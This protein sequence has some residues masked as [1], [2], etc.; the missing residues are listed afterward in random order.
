MSI[1]SSKAYSYIVKKGATGFILFALVCLNLLVPHQH[2]RAEV[3][4]T[5]DAQKVFDAGSFYDVIWS[6]PTIT[7]TF[8]KYELANIGPV[9]GETSARVSR[10]PSSTERT[11]IEKAFE[12][13]DRALDSRT[14]TFT[15]SPNADIKVGFVERQDHPWFFRFYTRSQAP[16]RGNLFNGVIGFSSLDRAIINEGYFSALAHRRVANVLGMGLIL[17][18]NSNATVMKGDL[19]DIYDAHSGSSLKNE[20]ARYVPTDYEIGLIR[21]LYGESTC[22][23]DFGKKFDEER[24]KEA[25]KQEELEKARKAFEDA[26][27]RADA[28]VAAS[29]AAAELKAKEEAEAEAKAKAATELRAKQEAEAISAAELKAEQEAAAKAAVLKKTTVICIK[30]KLTKKVTAVKPKCPTG[31][32]LKK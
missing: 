12:N 6:S 18:T 25:K 15:T 3:C 13:W 27:V 32:K 1:N 14:I 31:Y 29:K 17:N 22:P 19:Q 24:N 23:S 9:W 30:G 21:S 20:G 26:R 16:P 7:W 11:I 5:Y 8:E 4:P 10:I 28:E 2:A